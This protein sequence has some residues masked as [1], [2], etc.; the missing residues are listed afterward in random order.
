MKNLNIYELCLKLGIG[1]SKVYEMLHEGKLPGCYKE[2]R[3]WIFPEDEIDRYIK[4]KKESQKL[5][6]EDHDESNSEINS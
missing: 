3:K 2:G 1:K 4:S 6:T 5:E